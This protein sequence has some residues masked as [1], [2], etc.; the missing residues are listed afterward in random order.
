MSEDEESI[1]YI[2]SNTPEVLDSDDPD[3][4]E[5]GIY[6][7]PYSTGFEMEFDNNGE[8]TSD[9]FTD[10]NLLD[11]DINDSEQRFRIDN[12]I[13]GLKQL[14]GISRILRKYAI[15]SD[16]SGIHYH[17][18][19]TDKYNQFT[20]KNVNDNWE[21]IQ[22]ELIHWE[23]GGNYNKQGYC[24]IYNKQNDEPNKYNG[25]WLRFNSQFK[26]MEYRIGNMTFDYRVLF[27]RI[28]HANYITKTLKKVI[29]IEA[30]NDTILKYEHKNKKIQKVLKNRTIKI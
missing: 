25:S 22:N 29:E 21:W 19:C 30:I 16:Y 26:T 28:V 27:K 1:D 17:I 3:V 8:L 13:I 9:M 24:G 4:I 18:D 11:L 7:L 6:Y 2:I 5:A 10:L 12:G 20:C 23:Y 15:F 14:S